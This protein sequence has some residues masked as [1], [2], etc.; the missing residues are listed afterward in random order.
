MGLSIHTRVVENHYKNWYNIVFC[1]LA[2]LATTGLGIYELVAR[3]T[4][5]LK[6]NPNAS[7]V[8]NQELKLPVMGPNINIEPSSSI[9]LTV[10]FN[11]VE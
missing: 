9:P 10:D 7:W 3:Q 1:G 8:I 11:V 5:T 6:T 4:L 2:L